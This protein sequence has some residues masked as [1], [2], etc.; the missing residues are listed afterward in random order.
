MKKIVFFLTALVAACSLT[1]CDESDAEYGSTAAFVTV[2]NTSPVTFYTD[3]GEYLILGKDRTNYPAAF[4]LRSLLY[5]NV[6][7]T[8]EVTSS[9]SKPIDLFA[10]Y[11][12]DEAATAVLA[13]G[14]T[15]NYGEYDVDVY[16]QGSQYFLVHASKSVIDIA[17][18]Y[19]AKSDDTTKHRFTLVLDETAPHTDDQNLHLRLCHAADASE[20]ENTSLM[21]SLVTF[22]LEDFADYIEGTNGVTITAA[23]VNTSS[24]VQHTFQWAE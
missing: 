18:F 23:G 8:A 4:G 5:Y 2:V 12:F 17:L 16:M 20:M 13:E 6:L 14:E 3:N 7:Q 22:S 24:D 15:N 1:A 21:A 11:N 10:Y 9:S 19:P